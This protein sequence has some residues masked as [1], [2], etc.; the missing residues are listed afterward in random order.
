MCQYQVRFLEVTTVLVS[1][2]LLQTVIRHHQSALLLAQLRATFDCSE[3]GRH[4][5]PLLCE[6]VSEVLE[7]LRRRR[8]TPTAQERR[9]SGGRG[10]AGNGVV[11]VGLS[12][13]EF[14]C[15]A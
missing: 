9:K 13:L 5:P 3:E 12:Y 10:G 15:K 14:F 8:T 6:G 1:H 2:F 11:C 4:R 7:H